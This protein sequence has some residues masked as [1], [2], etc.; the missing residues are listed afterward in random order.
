MS[1]SPAVASSPPGIARVAG[2]T[3][4]VATL[5]T[6]P[7][8]AHH[9]SIT[10]AHDAADVLRRMVALRVADEA[11]HAVVIAITAALL[12][13]FAAYAARRGP[14]RPLVLAGLVAYALGSVTVIGAGAIDGFI[15]PGIAARY[16]GATGPQ[17][18]IAVQMITAA[19]IAIQVLTKIWLIAT[20]CAVIAWSA[21]LA[22]ERGIV[23]GAA[24]A[25]FVTSAAV[26]AVAAFA[27]YVN[28]HVLG[29]VVL[30][31]SLWNVGIGVLLVRGDL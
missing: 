25:G 27:G 17:I 7:A 9:P 12:F 22:H 29:I 20:A 26:V 4:I 10:R 24:V 21:D 15:I 5:A 8:V 30:V 3:L 19:A 14:A 31:Q 11:V 28:P 1:E 18:A 2:I 16:V 6:I 13:G 23:R